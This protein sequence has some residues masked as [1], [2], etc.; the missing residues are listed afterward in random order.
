MSILAYTIRFNM[1]EA[2][3]V[4]DLLHAVRLFNTR[5]DTVPICLCRYPSLEKYHLIPI[6][7]LSNDSALFPYLLESARV[8]KPTIVASFKILTFEHV[9]WK[10]QQRTSQQ[11]IEL[12]GTDL[13][14]PSCLS[15]Q[16]QTHLVPFSLFQYL[17]SLPPYFISY[18]RKSPTFAGLFRRAERTTRLP[19]GSPLVK[20]KNSFFP[21]DAVPPVALSA[22][23]PPHGYRFVLWKW[24]CV[25]EGPGYIGYPYRPPAA[26]WRMYGGTYAA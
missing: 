3:S 18:M 1:L 20:G 10:I 11:K 15:L 16:S 23:P 24:S 2:Y 6:S 19:P 13:A 8:S 21:S 22:V 4:K 5:K 17:L 26:R 7:V 25:Q 12:A 9:A 14:E